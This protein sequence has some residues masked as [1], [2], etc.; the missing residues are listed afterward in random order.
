MADL[1]EIGAI[2]FGVLRPPTV[3]G[4]LAERMPLA[5]FRY[6]GSHFY[7]SKDGQDIRLLHGFCTHH[8]ILA[9]TN[10]VAADQCIPA[11]QLTLP[12]NFPQKT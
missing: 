10:L 11:T 4:F 1:W 6:L 2:Y 7:F 5:N 8:T 12:S 3:E 9:Q